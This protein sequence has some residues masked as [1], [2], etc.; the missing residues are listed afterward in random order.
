MDL[1]RDIANEAV[2]ACRKDGYHVAA[3]VVDRHG[4]LRAALRDDIASVYMLQIAQEKANLVIMAGIP[5]AEFR[6]KRSDIRPELNHLD[7]IIVMG[8]GLPI[9]AGGSRI[10]AVAVAGAPGADKDLE[11]AE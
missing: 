11:F 2:K 3:V 8:G 4:N 6:N 5:S 9:D 10:G 7:G 1:A